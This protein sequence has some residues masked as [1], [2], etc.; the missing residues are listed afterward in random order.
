[1]D[2]INIEKEYSSYYQEIEIYKKILIFC[3]K[4]GEYLIYKIINTKNI[5]RVDLHML[6]IYSKAD[7]PKTTLRDQYF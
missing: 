1:M 4:N 7:F 6:N 3:P 5:I 2:M